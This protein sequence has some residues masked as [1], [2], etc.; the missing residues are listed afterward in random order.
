LEV[1]EEEDDKKKKVKKGEKE[2]TEKEIKEAKKLKYRRQNCHNPSYKELED[3]IK[4]LSEFKTNDKSNNSNINYNKLI[5]D[6]DK[7]ISD[8]Q[9]L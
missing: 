3:K 1:E 9:E 4:D 5:Q 2:P 6:K 7:E 8:L